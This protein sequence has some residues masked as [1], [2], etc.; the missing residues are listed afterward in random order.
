MK[1]FNEQG[2]NETNCDMRNKSQ[3]SVGVENAALT[4]I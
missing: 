2:R 1:K 3:V 4:C